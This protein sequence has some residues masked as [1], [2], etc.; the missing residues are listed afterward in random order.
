MTWTNATVLNQHIGVYEGLSPVHNSV[1]PHLKGIV[2]C[3]IKGGRTRTA[4]LVTQTNITGHGHVHHEKQTIYPVT[5]MHEGGRIRGP[6]SDTQPH[7]RKMVTVGTVYPEEKIILVDAVVALS[8][9]QSGH[10]ATFVIQHLAVQQGLWLYQS[11]GH[12]LENGFT[13]GVRATFEV[14]RTD[15]VRLMPLEGVRNR[16]FT[17][18]ILHGRI[19]SGVQI[20]FAHEK[21]AHGLTGTFGH[22]SVVEHRW[23]PHITQQPV[24]VFR[25]IRA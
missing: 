15:T 8:L 13:D 20:P 7:I 9:Q 17:V 12:G 1:I 16:H 11:V 24:N 6:R 21:A 2:V 4:L 14:V 22:H 25:G 18:V 23:F 10:A 5:G 3:H 19:H